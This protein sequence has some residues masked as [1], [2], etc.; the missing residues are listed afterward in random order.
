MPSK[1]S[2]QFD[3]LF[4]CLSFGLSGLP[5]ADPASTC[6]TA[7]G[8]ASTLLSTSRPLSGLNEL[9]SLGG[10]STTMTA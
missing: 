9:S 5:L 1:M 10:F 3:G 7:A 6:F 8:F 2:P 4:F